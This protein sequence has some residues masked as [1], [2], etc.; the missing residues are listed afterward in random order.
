MSSKSKSPKTKTNLSDVY[1]TILDNVKPSKLSS[2]VYR[3][4][5]TS[6]SYRNIDIGDDNKKKLL[7]DTT[8]FSYK[9][10]YISENKEFKYRKNQLNEITYIGIP[11]LNI[12]N[13]IIKSDILFIF[14]NNKSTIKFKKNKFY[15]DA[16]LPNSDKY[17]ST[18]WYAKCECSLLFDNYK[19]LFKVLKSYPK[20]EEH[21]TL[22]EFMEDEDKKY[23]YGNQALYYQSIP[24]EELNMILRDKEYPIKKIKI[25]SFVMEDVEKNIGSI[26]ISYK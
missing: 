18:D 26:Y 5:T 19:P 20:L 13:L 8:H 24:F 10:E 2:T 7:F 11:I 4:N 21:E 3:L 23:D 14:Q 15:F 6:K 25:D 9:G 1:S 16:V 17:S 22:D 12:L